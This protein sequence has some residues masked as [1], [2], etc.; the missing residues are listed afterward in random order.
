MR[1][2]TFFKKT[3]VLIV[4]FDFAEGLRPSSP[5]RFCGVDVGEVKDV[6]VRRKDGEQPVVYVHIKISGDSHIP[7]NSSFFING[8]SLF[9]E[10]YLEIMPPINPEGYLQEGDVVEG[11]SPTPLFYVTNNLHKTMTE[12]NEFLKDGK[13][14]QSFENTINNVEKIS[15]DV[16]QLIEDVRNKKGTVGKL[17]YDDSLYIKTE[18][19]IEDLKENPWK[20]LHKPRGAK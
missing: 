12:V 6:E 7:R 10:K 19:F 20:L 9:G 14:K 5:V 1:E 4:K 16:R 11:Y 8:L 2:F 18:E 15:E 3:Q 13:I 17:F